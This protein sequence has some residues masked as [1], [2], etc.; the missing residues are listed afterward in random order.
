MA[1]FSMGLAITLEAGRGSNARLRH[2][3]RALALFGLI[4]GAHEWV[5]MFEQLGMLPGQ[6]IDPVAWHTTRIAILE[7]SF[8]FLGAFGATLLPTVKNF[9]RASVLVPLLLATV[10]GV[11]LVLLRGY[12]TIETGL[13]DVADVW[14]R[15][16][17]AVPSA[18]LACVGL[19]GQRRVFRQE[20][21]PQFGRA[22]LVAAIAFAWYGIIGQTF[23]R[24]SPLPPSAV[25]NEDLFLRLFGF[26]VQLLR[27]GAAVISAYAVIRF[28][29]SF[30]VETQRKIAELQDAQLREA[31]RREA[32]RGELFRRVVS[33][34]EAE[35]QRI[36]RELH[37]ETGQALTAIGLGLRGVSGMLRQDV[38]KASANLRQLEGMVARALTEL[39]R[40]IADL[41]PSHLDDLGL[42][43]ALRWY[44]GEVQNRVSLPVHVEV[45]GEPRPIDPA[46]NTALFRIAQEALTNVVKHAQARHA[47]VELAYGG[48]AVSVCVEDDGRGF[49]LFALKKSKRLA[50]G[51]V[52]M[53][54]RASLLR[55]QLDLQ[56]KLG[57]GT[58][59]EVTIPYYQEAEDGHDNTLAAGG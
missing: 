36:G 8:L 38:D 11:G 26:P 46:V 55:G 17:V 12:F 49:D 4:H 25:I 2:G 3:L 41:R 53:E 29:R 42:P 19:I 15:Y 30:E 35:R 16:V 14:T 1:F 40:L 28:L 27:A 47:R 59:V 21:M 54:E 57:R 23:T 24:A 13:W 45:I 39:Q 48:A 51:L 18:L 7:F 31:Q 32:Q 37:D 20:G 50:W 56:S 58:R 52:G 34:Q 5:E 33:A 10:W 22:S 44:A 43:A 9:R 6:D